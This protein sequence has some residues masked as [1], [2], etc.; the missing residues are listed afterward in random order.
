MS[1][2]ERKKA[3]IALLLLVPAPT[4]GVWAAMW[5]PSLRGSGVG[6]VIYA[7]TKVWILVLPLIW[8]KLVVGK[9]FEVNRP[10]GMAMGWLSGIAIGVVILLFYLAIGSKLLDPESIRTTATAN[11]LDQAWKYLGLVLYLSFVN[12][13]L[14]EMVWR[15]FVQTQFETLFPTWT[16]AILSAGCFT[17]HHVFAL[18]AQMDWVA[19]L[20]ASLGVFVGGCIWS[21]CRA[22]YRNVWPGYVSH[23]LADLAIFWIGWQILFAAHG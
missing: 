10:H 19:T 3:V 6:Q 9:P 20:L 15:W 18:K 4:L 22:R 12:S 16:A 17:L 5:S 1:L 2:D 14:E 11:G 7:V 13:L 21:W 23:I 8:H